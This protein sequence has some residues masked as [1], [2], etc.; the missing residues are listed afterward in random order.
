MASRPNGP[1]RRRLQPTFDDV[2][3]RVLCTASTITVPGTANPYLADTSN[4]KG[5]LTSR[6]GTAPPSIDVSGLSVLTFAANGGTANYPGGPRPGPDGGGVV[7]AL[8]GARGEVSSWRLPIDMLAGVFLG[9]TRTAAPGPYSGSLSAVEVSPQIGQVFPI[10]DGLTGHGSGVRQIVHVPKGATRL[11]LANT[12][13]YEWSNNNGQFTVTV[14]PAPASVSVVSFAKN[15]GT[16]PSA[17][18]NIGSN[19]DYEV[20]YRVNGSDI[21]ARPDLTLAVYWATGPK[22]TDVIP[23]L[24]AVATDRLQTALGPHTFA[25]HL[26][27]LVNPPANAKGLV[28]VLDDKHVLPPAAEVDGV[29]YLADDTSRLSGELESSVVTPPPDAP[30]REQRV[31]LW[32]KG[33]SGMILKAAADFH[34]D[35]AAVAGAI[36]WEALQ[37]V[38]PGIVYGPGK[39]HPF[40]LGKV[41]AAEFVEGK[42]KYAP[43]LPVQN[44][45]TRTALLATPGGAIRYIAGIMNAYA[46]EAEH[47]PRGRDIRNAP[48]ILATYFNGAGGFDLPDAPAGFRNRFAN[49]S[50]LRP[51]TTMGQ[52]VANNLA[53]LRSALGSSPTGY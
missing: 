36:A 30:T 14:N 29:G 50:P 16:D 4:A 24:P 34:L 7:P 11:F 13:G 28:V 42:A 17:P 1:A 40:E 44:V 21:A 41:A 46:Y 33:Y 38:K 22:T 18:G 48:G 9:P 27:Q 6:D 10:G 5:P 43:T 51:G 39:V 20:H 23:G 19:G 32:L 49:P 25:V 47:A 8:Y 15:V 3:R 35:P 37:N 31:W 53:Y 2:E 12:D 45:V 26:A 52:W